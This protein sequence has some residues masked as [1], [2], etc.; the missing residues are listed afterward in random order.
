MLVCR[1]PDMAVVTAY[2]L[3]PIR[4]VLDMV[5]VIAYLLVPIHHDLVRDPR[6]D[7]VPGRLTWDRKVRQS[8][9]SDILLHSNQGGLSSLLSR[10][11]TADLVLMA[12]LGTRHDQTSL[13]HSRKALRKIVLHPRIRAP[14]ME[15]RHQT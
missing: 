4:Q 9:T 1:V 6:N 15:I 7:Q 12:L 5:V 13:H 14:D 2:L 11:A 10:M 3:V 8:L